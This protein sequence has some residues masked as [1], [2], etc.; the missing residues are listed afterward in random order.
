MVS[1][2]IEMHV[3]KL[4]RIV[5]YKEN[6]R[7]ARFRLLE[8]ERERGGGCKVQAGRLKGGRRGLVDVSNGDSPDLN[9]CLL[10]E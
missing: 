2:I 7:N 5:G 10:E 4:T 3:R 6:R 8:R 1:K 9:Y